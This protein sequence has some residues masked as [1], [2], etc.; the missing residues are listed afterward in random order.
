MML[1]CVQ[2]LAEIYSDHSL[3]IALNLFFQL[4]PLP[5]SC[6]YFKSF[7]RKKKQISMYKEGF[8]RYG[9]V[10]IFIAISLMCTLTAVWGKT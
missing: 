8:M 6:Q 4:F 3:K 7:W 5:A 9:R 2:L 10:A 1:G